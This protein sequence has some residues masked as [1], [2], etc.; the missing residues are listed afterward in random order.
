MRRLVPYQTGL[1]LAEYLYIRCQLCR[2]YRSTPQSQLSRTLS[3]HTLSPLKNTAALANT[4]DLLSTSNLSKPLGSHFLSAKLFHQLNA[5]LNRGLLCARCHDSIAWLPTPFEVDIAAGRTLS[6]QAA[7]YYDYPMRQAI[8]AFKHHEDMTKLPLLLHAIRQLPRPHGC[9][10]DNSVIVVMPTT[11]QRLV[12]RGFD[13]V[14]ILSAQ[15]SQH[16][17]IPL[18]QGVRRV[19]DTV[20]Q[21]GLS[22]AERLSNL[23]NAFA[24][25]ST[26][27]VKRL[28]LFDDVATTGASLQALSRTLLMPLTATTLDSQTHNR[29]QLSAYALAH[30]HQL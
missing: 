18:W 4:T 9:H 24:L 30:G 11:N 26:P 22:R 27:P 20:S 16:W 28:L 7:T 23:D 3:P 5:R 29:Y 13:P 12:K 19:D 14:S 10:H 17:R 8:R 21:Q 2:I 1:W 25:V 6:I 15:L